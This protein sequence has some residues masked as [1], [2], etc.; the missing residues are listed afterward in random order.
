M[1]KPLEYTIFKQWFIMRDQEP[2]PYLSLPLIGGYVECKGV[3][4]AAGFLRLCEGSYG[5]I[6]S[7]ATNPE[8]FPKER[9]RAMDFLVELLLS[10]ANKMHMAVIVAFTFDNNTLERAARYGFT[11]LPHKVIQKSLKERSKSWVS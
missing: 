1:N 5:M 10:L 2:P 8:A 6:D 3:A 11:Q 9:D 7:V 4:V